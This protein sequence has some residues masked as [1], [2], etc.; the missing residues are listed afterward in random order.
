MYKNDKYFDNDS[1]NT[2]KKDLPKC[3]Q[4]IFFFHDNETKSSRIVKKKK[5]TWS[6][7]FGS[8][9][10]YETNDDSD[11]KTET[12]DNFALYFN[13]FYHILQESSKDMVD[14]YVVNISLTDEE[15]K[16]IEYSARGHQ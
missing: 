16:R 15:L 2:L 8:G 10:W 6:C 7:W 5:W 3:L 9:I 1:M 14:K 4:W 12:A 13:S 11:F